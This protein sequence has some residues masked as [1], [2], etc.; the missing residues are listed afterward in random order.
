M[1]SPIFLSDRNL[2]EHCITQQN[3][4][5]FSLSSIRKDRL[6]G[7]IGL[8]FRRLGGTILYNPS[9]IWA[10]IAGNPIIQPERHPA[11]KKSAGKGRGRPKKE[12]SISAKR[13]GISVSQ[14]R[15]AAAGN[16]RDSC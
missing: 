13:Q 10:F 7:R 15:A 8:P 2:I 3:P 14:L 11:L 16:G 1:L 5:P 6:D 4:L 9:E 12:E